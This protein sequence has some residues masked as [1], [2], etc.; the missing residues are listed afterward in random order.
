[1]PLIFCRLLSP[2]AY[3]WCRKNNF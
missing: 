1:M 3:S 2:R